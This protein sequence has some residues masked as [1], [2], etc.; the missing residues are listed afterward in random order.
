M[1][2]TG[3]ERTCFKEAAVSAS[4]SFRSLAASNVLFGEAEGTT[5]AYGPHFVPA[6]RQDSRYVLMSSMFERKPSCSCTISDLTMAPLS[7]SK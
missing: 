5:S 6:G 1:N 2:E 7:P 3:I 4:M